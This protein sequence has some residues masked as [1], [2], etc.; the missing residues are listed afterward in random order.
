MM[1]QSGNKVTLE[2]L[3]KI[4]F[5]SQFPN[6]SLEFWIGLSYDQTCQLYTPHIFPR[7]LFAIFDKRHINHIIT[8]YLTGFVADRL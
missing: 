3:N 5:A 8:A 6:N 2:Q 4:N 1:S 7:I